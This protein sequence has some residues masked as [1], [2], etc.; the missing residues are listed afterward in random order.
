MRIGIFLLYHKRI[1]L[2]L[3][4]LFDGVQRWSLHYSFFLCLAQTQQH[5]R[6][7]FFI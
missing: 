7:F 6:L 3:K 5:D 2:L 4:A 1:Y